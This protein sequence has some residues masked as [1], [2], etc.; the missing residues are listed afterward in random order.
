MVSCDLF[1]RSGW[2]VPATT[3]PEQRAAAESAPPHNQRRQRSLSSRCTVPGSAFQGGNG[4]GHGPDADRMIECNRNG[5][6]W[7]A[8]EPAP[9]LRRLQLPPPVQQ[10][11]RTPRRTAFVPSVRGTHDCG[12]TSRCHLIHKH[13]TDLA[14][15]APH[16]TTPRRSFGRKPWTST[17][18]NRGW[19]HSLDFRGA[20]GA[21]EKNLVLAPQSPGSTG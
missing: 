5:R 20:E 12:A 18:K 17:S 9:R 15:T 11:N 16:C 8:G 10:R 7:R 3:P 1:Q 4:S 21:A 19:A 13:T 6:G 2:V 14:S